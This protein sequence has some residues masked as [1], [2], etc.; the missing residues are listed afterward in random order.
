[1]KRFA[2]AA[3]LAVLAGSQADAQYSDLVYA[4]SSYYP[5]AVTSR[6]FPGTVNGYY[7]PQFAT[8]GNTYYNNGVVPANTYGPGYLYSSS[9]YYSTP[10][11]FSPAT[12]GTS[13]YTP[14]YSYYSPGYTSYRSGLFRRG[15]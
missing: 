1:M 4:P 15:W 13:F 3:V 9:G 14:T 6:Y 11:F 8:F 12:I 10:S 2:L 7:T 5:S